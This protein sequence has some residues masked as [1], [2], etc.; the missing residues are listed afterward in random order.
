MSINRIWILTTCMVAIAGTAST[1]SIAVSSSGGGTAKLTA[2]EYMNISGNQWTT[3]SRLLKLGE[4]IEFRFT[5]ATSVNAGNLYIY[6]NFLEKARPG[7]KFALNGNLDWLNDLD[8]QEIKLAFTDGKASVVYKPKSPGSYMA[9]W[10]A[11]DETMYRYFSVI[12][13]DWVVVRFNTWC[14]DKLD[15][16]LQATGIPLDYYLGVDGFDDKSQS[17]LNLLRLNHLYGYTVMPQLP[18]TP[19]MEREGRLRLYRE[20][21]E[22]ARG[23]LLDESNSRSIRLE[24]NH[25]IDPGY[26]E[27]LERLGIN[28][29]CGMFEANGGPWL[30]MPE[31]PYYS[32]PIDCRKINQGEGGS[33]IGHQWD[34]CGGWHFLG[35]AFWHYSTSEG[36]WS[37]AKKCL[38]QGIDELSNA[39]AMSKHPVFAYY[40]YD[41]FMEDYAYPKVRFAGSHDKKKG[42]E[43]MEKYQRFLAFEAPKAHK[44]VYARSIDMA[45]YF[46]RHNKVTPRTIYSCKTD[47]VQ[48]DKWWLC[49]WS[50]GLFVPREKIPWQTQTSA[51]LAERN[52]KKDNKFPFFKDPLSYEYLLVED[53]KRS[54]RFERESPNP[55]W[56]HDYSQQTRTSEGSRITYTNTP[57]VEI[58]RTQSYDGNIGLSIKLKMIT[59]VEFKDYAIVLWGLPVEYNSIPD[60]ERAKV[61]EAVLTRNIDG[62]VH[63]VIIFDLKPDLELEIVFHEPTAKK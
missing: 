10:T 54:I 30:G 35:P 24:V 27:A 41:G 39:A 34:F 59:N 53:Q 2:G 43:F 11:G 29:H 44:L 1:D 19:D 4:S 12:E 17:F 6:P 37:K 46:I 25:E 60:L 38:T 58:V 42:M 36:N 15:P 55:I 8:S 26:T 51:I 20:K 49:N 21:M 40:L 28:D 31:F 52:L 33:V 22:K 7:N 23:F 61:S 63:M 45:D 9:R 13:D 57:D 14:G 16:T 32:S 56:W 62:E 50:C 3:G 47:H 5:L 48:Y 18:D